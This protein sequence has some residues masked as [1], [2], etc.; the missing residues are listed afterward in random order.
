MIVPEWVIDRLDGETVLE[1][2]STYLKG[3]S[4]PQTDHLGGQR[5]Q[6]FS[7]NTVEP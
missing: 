6:P 2:R 3:L 4:I 7:S 1:A 5:Q